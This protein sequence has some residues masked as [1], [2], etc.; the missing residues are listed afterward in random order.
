MNTT[1][2]AVLVFNFFPLG[3]TALLCMTVM[4]FSF[5][6]VQTEKG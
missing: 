5:S 4:R 6:F 3:T 1:L 2:T